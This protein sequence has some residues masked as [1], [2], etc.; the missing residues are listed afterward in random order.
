MSPKTLILATKVKFRMV[1]L[2]FPQCNRRPVLPVVTQRVEGAR[3]RKSD[4]GLI[5]R[6]RLLTRADLQRPEAVL[7]PSEAGMTRAPA[8]D[9]IIT[10]FVYR[11]RVLYSVS[12]KN[13]HLFG[14]AVWVGHSR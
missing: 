5:S 7:T 1:P 14:G 13:G 10:G 6:P 9:N 3:G 4:G 11:T 8:P 2:S 12:Q